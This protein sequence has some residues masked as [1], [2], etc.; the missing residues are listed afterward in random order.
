MKKP[1]IPS[2]DPTK[3]NVQA[4]K[5]VV[6]IITGRRGEKLVAIPPSYSANNLRAKI[7][8]ILDLLQDADQLAE[9]SGAL[10]VGTATAAEH[11]VRLE[12]TNISGPAFSAYLPTAN[13][14]VT[15]AV[16][17]KVTLSAEEFDTNSNFDSATNYRFTPTVEGYY[18]FSFSLT[19]DGSPVAAVSGA[20]YKNGALYKAGTY[21]QTA[22]VMASSG[23]ALV[24]MNGTTDYV[25][26]FGYVV[27][28]TPVII[29]AAYNTFL[30]GCL[31]RR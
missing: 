15:S 13:Q 21:I 20:L 3:K 26:L 6:E 10:E 28:T 25:E 7:N 11:A 5:E 18:Q 16:W 8:Q 19:G 29:F 1:A 14:S 27:G 30:T 2:G 22:T 23:S 4:L 24:Y 9:T 17:T 12:Q 31:I